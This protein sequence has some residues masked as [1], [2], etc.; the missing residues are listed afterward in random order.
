[1]PR[2]GAVP[3]I[4]GITVTAVLTDNGAC[5]RSRDFAGRTR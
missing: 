4:A 1:M 3:V 5:Y 2:C